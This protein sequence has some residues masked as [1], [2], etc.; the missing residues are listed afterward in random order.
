MDTRDG[1]IYSSEQMERLRILLPT[2]DLRHIK[3]M[4]VP[5][6]PEQLAAGKVDPDDWCPC[7]SWKRFKDCC[8]TGTCFTGPEVNVTHVTV[9][10]PSGPIAGTKVTVNGKTGVT[11]ADGTCSLE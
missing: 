7:G 2:E 10:G 5:P 11:A 8:F 3:E 1:R 9:T 4:E 6:T